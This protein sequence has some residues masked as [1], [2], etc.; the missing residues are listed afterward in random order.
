MSAISTGGS[1][2]DASARSE[3]APVMATRSPRGT[4]A[5]RGTSLAAGP[6]DDALVMPMTVLVGAD[7]EDPARSGRAIGADSLGESQQRGAVLLLQPPAC[8][9]FRQD[10]A[11][12]GGVLGDG[13][14]GGGASGDW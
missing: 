8:G 5:R 6:G 12:A 4:P 14:G 9:G 7:N 3:S 1:C 13:S 2:A 11:T 10:D